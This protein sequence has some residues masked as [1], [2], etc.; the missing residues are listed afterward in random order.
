[1]PTNDRLRRALT[2]NRLTPA[3]LA[4]AVGVS[5]RAVAKW[6]AGAT[7]F[8]KNRNAVA[9][10]LNC[11]PAALWPDAEAPVETVKSEIVAA[12]PRRSD[13]P[14]DYWW[15]LFEEA[16][17]QID[18]L[19][20]AVQ[21]LTEYLPDVVEFLGQRAAAECAVRIIIANPD[22]EATRARDTEEGLNSGLISRVRS[23]LKYLGPLFSSDASIRFQTVPMYNSMFRFDDEMLVTPHLYAT[24]G[25][26]APLLHVRRLGAGGLF[27]GFVHHFEGIWAETTPARSPG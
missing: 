18:I 21:F 19:G 13:C 10:A 20:Y 9:A 2:K 27:D 12:W 4:E 22:A 26:L 7:P 8:P 16:S 6:L 14:A 11:D 17:S 25:R 15:H 3:Q 5:E 24:P 23:S 1:M